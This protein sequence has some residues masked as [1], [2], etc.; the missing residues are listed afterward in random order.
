M[1]IRGFAFA[2]TIFF[3]V[4]FAQADI[5]PIEP[6]SKAVF[7]SNTSDKL[8]RVPA[9]VKWKKVPDASYYY[10]LLSKYENFD[11]GK[12]FRTPRAQQHLMIYPN[13]VY[14]WQ[15]QAFDAKGG[16][17]PFESY[18]P[19]R[20]EG[21]FHGVRPVANDLMVSQ[22]EGDRNLASDETP[23]PKMEETGV[24]ST[25]DYGGKR[26]Q[27]NSGDNSSARAPRQEMVV[28][29]V[30]SYPKWLQRNKFWIS[31]EAGLFRF[32][33]NHSV[34]TDVNANGLM[35]PSFGLNYQTRDFWDHLAAK[36]YF[37]N[38]IGSFETNSTAISML[39]DDFQFLQYGAVG[40]WTLNSGK[41]FEWVPYLGVEQ[42]ANPYFLQISP[43]SIT[44]KSMDI[45]SAV[46][47]LRMNFS[48]NSRWRHHADVSYYQI[49]NAKT[50]DLGSSDVSGTMYEAQLGMTRQFTKNGFFA[51]GAL[52]AS[53]RDFKEDV[54]TTANQASSGT[55]DTTYYA[56]ELN[57]G[58]VF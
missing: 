58:I 3:F 45:T 16:R 56:F 53:L 4:G 46:A 44:V 39:D 18:S 11:E 9:Q 36:I 52:R 50:K 14:Y 10:L 43:T 57:A 26:H 20:V 37:R 25:Y 55:R 12:L 2:F 41:R 6:T 28:R 22:E 1:G 29:V 49:L 7:T 13:M 47:G 15:V 23:P 32:Q 38:T 33:Q 5:A 35:F 21:R 42:Q 17:L 8:G 54:V 27:E 31:T 30:E 40:Q 51:G 19:H 24:L 34:L 48:P